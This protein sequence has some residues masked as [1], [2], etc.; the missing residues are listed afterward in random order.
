MEAEE[1]TADEGEDGEKIWGADNVEDAGSS[2]PKTM[3]EASV[4]GTMRSSATDQEQVASVLLAHAI[5]NEQE[6]RTEQEA[7]VP[8]AVTRER[9]SRKRD[10]SPSADLSDE[11]DVSKESMQSRK[12][13]KVKASSRT[14][15]E[16]LQA[17]LCPSALSYLT[18]N[19][20]KLERYAIEE[21]P[22]VSGSI[23]EDTVLGAGQEIR[24]AV[25]EKC[26]VLQSRLMKIADGGAFAD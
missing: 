19:L 1:A 6:A 21:Y 2:G 11:T 4:H 18:Q 10:I 22:M 15:A 12:K 13:F 25:C 23:A 26:E 14:M 17:P 24:K 20:N 9:K 7:P 8:A 16:A 5:Q 3:Q